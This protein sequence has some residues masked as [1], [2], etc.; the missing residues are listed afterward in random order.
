MS[1]ARYLWSVLLPVG[2][3]RCKHCSIATG[4]VAARLPDIHAGSS[5]YHVFCYRCSQIMGLQPVPADSPE[6]ARLQ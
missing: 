4:T 1:M 3:G 2:L 5:T 6:S